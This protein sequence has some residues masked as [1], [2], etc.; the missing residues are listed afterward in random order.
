MK[1][2]PEHERQS[3]W[4]FRQVLAGTLDSEVVEVK[5]PEGQ[6]ETH[7]PSEAKRFPVHVRQKSAEP[8]QVP[9]ELEQAKSRW[10]L[11]EISCRIRISTYEHNFC[12][13]EG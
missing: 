7:W 1:E 12:Y 3:G 9:H 13:L 10:L 2:G 11:P 6:V 4:H 5:V 8:A